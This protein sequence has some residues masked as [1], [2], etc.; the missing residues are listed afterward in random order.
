MKTADE[1]KRVVMGPLA[2]L[3]VVE[4]VGIGP[5]PFC[6]MLLADM[7]AEVIRVDQPR[8]GPLPA[9]YSALNT[10]FDIQARGRRSIAVNLKAPAGPE[11][12]L[13]LIDQ[14]DALIEGFRPGVM[15]RLGLGPD[16][17]LGR[18]SKLVFGRM[19]GWGQD[20]PL[21]QAPGHDINYIALTGAL[22]AMGHPDHP[23]SPPL[24]LVGDLGGGGMLLA[25]GMVCAML[26]ARR[27]GQGQVVD[28]AMTDGSALLMAMFY[29]LRA[30][31]QWRDERQ[32]NLVDGGAHFY[33][34]FACLDGK[35]IAI[36]PLEP[37]FYKR[38]LAL[39]EIADPAFE[40]QMEP[41][42]WPALRQTLADVFR[43]RTC[44]EW[45]GMLEG[46]DACFAPVLNMEEAPGHPHNVARQTFIEIDGVTQP[47]PAPRFSR[48]PTGTPV[49]PPAVGEHSREI[50]RDWQFS[51][52]QIRALTADG[53]VR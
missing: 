52:D 26:E 49:R 33:G 47:A 50:L 51:A 27:S 11:T 21:A 41:S 6:A 1:K 53:V 25:F 48:T 42:R 22:A 32:A 40:E 3:K 24:N 31:G 18:N 12:V 28:A 43:T 19:T 4:M 14:A 39:C 17:C 20:G 16:V 37:H 29:G 8:S 30:A 45:C 38:L 23:P 15:E 10:R 13:K 2:G 36:G 9:A 7:G 34:S 44:A 5:G 35:Y 46:T